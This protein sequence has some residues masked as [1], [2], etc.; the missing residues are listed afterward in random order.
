M[1]L[2]DVTPLSLGIETLGGVMTCSFRATRRFRRRRRETF[3][4]ADDNQTTVEIH[5]LQGERD[6]ARDNRTLGQVPAH[7]NSARSARHAAD[8]GHVRH[9]RERH[10]ARVGQGQGD[11][12]GTEDP[13]RG[14]ERSLRLRHRPHGEGRREE[15][16]GRQEAARGD[17]RAQS[18][19]QYD[20]R[21]REEREGVVGH[22]CRP[23]S[24][25]SSTRRSSVRARRF[26]ATTR[27]RFAP[28]KK[29]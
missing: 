10:S 3:S 23:S 12:Q 14:V 5:V 21:G 6:M 29:S 26:A 8:R 28:R 25:P 22:G 19:R 20:V 2:L 4:T 13:H 17:R 24:R 7:R 16:H 11:E 18:S 1:L 27:T 15:R 9:R